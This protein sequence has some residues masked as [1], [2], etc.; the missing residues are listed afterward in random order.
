LILFLVQLQTVS[1]ASFALSKGV[2]EHVGEVKSPT[3]HRVRHQSSFAQRAPDIS[4]LSLFGV[5]SDLAVERDLI[6]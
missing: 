3:E 5:L 1:A 6:S 2:R 4:A